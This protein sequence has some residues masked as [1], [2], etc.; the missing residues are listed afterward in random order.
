[1][2]VS[3]GDDVDEALV[4]HVLRVRGFVT[5]DGFRESIGTHPAAILAALV[6]DGK[7]RH[8]EKRDMYGLLP[9]GKEYQE[10]LLDQYAGA[11]V[12]AGLHAH[13]EAF[14]ELNEAFK[15]LCTDWQMRGDQQNDHSDAAYDAEIV[16]RLLALNAESRPTLDGFAGALA[17][18]SRYAGRLDEALAKLEGGATNMFTGVMCGSYHDIWMELHED[19]IVLQRIDRVA[20]GSF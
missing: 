17:R 20:E 14:L 6:A 4:L 12:Q 9:P 3:G 18:M 19:L 11:D 5:P 13:Y 7:V 15:A 1:V 2:A 16:A 8:I 10:S